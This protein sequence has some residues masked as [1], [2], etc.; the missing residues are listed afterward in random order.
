MGESIFEKEVIET[1]QN[2]SKKLSTKRKKREVSDT[3]A[4][5][6][7]VKNYHL[8]GSF[9]LHKTKPPGISC[10]DIHPTKNLV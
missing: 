8:D 2:T 6:E 5:P 4:T 3:L 7:F 9:P 1:I 10:L